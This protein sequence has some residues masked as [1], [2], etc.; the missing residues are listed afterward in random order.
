[1]A[2]GFTKTDVERIANL[3]RLALGDNE[4]TVFAE[5][6]NDFLVYAEQVCELDTS[7]VAATSHVLD[8]L[9][10]D[11]ADEMRPSLTQT[12]ALG[13]APDPATAEGLFRV[14]RVLGG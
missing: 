3:A 11:R 10:A 1:M 7:G 8:R 14:P 2:A 4:K 13:N 5:Q 12:E 6:L 9:P